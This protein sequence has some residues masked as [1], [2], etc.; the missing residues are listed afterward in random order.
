MREPTLFWIRQVCTSFTDVKHLTFARNRDGR[1]FVEEVRGRVW[2]DCLATRVTVDWSTPA[3]MY[4]AMVV[5]ERCAAALSAEE[6]MEVVLAFQ[7]GPVS[8]NAPWPS[9]V[10]ITGAP[11]VELVPTPSKYSMPLP[12]LTGVRAEISTWSG[13][14][15]VTSNNPKGRG[16]S[17]FCSRRILDLAR[18]EGWTGFEFHPADLP[19]PL[20]G[21]WDGIDYLGHEWPPEHWYPPDPSTF[22]GVEDW[23]AAFDR[24]G[25]GAGSF[26]MLMV[27]E[28]GDW[29]SQKAIDWLAAFVI[30]QEPGTRSVDN[31]A[32]VYWSMWFQHRDLFSFDAIAVEK[33]RSIGHELDLMSLA[34]MRKRYAKKR[35]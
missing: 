32:R 31:A 10:A 6:T 14:D 26:S 16:Y 35:R 1:L 4:D 8:K 7:R 22:H 20:H 21:L 5:S 23:I 9:Y 24:V 11:G 15:F 25:Y 18:Q 29:S 27:R 3:S 30:E 2:T 19:Q 12:G 17:H 28:H 34:A 33:A 13:R